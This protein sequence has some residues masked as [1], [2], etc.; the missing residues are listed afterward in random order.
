MFCDDFHVVNANKPNSLWLMRSIEQTIRSACNT[1]MIYE[2][3]GIG[4]RPIWTHR[5]RFGVL[6]LSDETKTRVQ[7]A[8]ANIISDCYNNGTW[9]LYWDH[10]YNE[11]WYVDGE[12]RLE[13]CLDIAFDCDQQT[14]T[15]IPRVK[16]YDDLQAEEEVA[17]LTDQMT[18]MHLDSAQA[19]PEEIND[20]CHRFNNFGVS[21]QNGMDK[22]C[23]QF[24]NFGV[25]S[26][27]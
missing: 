10:D 5:F 3:V 18:D 17:L 27:F 2:W 6:N 9:S 26:T 23:Q 12:A 20:L 19:E 22:L 24:G 11:E 13:V 7:D 1:P 15:N 21:S 8:V 16:T 4:F 25:S 14:N